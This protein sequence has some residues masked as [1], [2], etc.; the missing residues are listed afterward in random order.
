MVT[1]IDIYDAYQHSFSDSQRGNSDGF[2]CNICGKSFT[3]KGNLTDHV[4]LHQGIYRY[5]CDICGKGFRSKM[6]YEGH[7]NTHTD[8]RPYK[9]SV[10]DKAFSYIQS[11]RKHVVI[12]KAPSYGWMLVVLLTRF[13]SFHT[14]FSRSHSYCQKNFE[15]Q[16]AKKLDFRRFLETNMWDL[17][18]CV[19]HHCK[20]T[21][22]RESP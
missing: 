14:W 13:I 16:Q 20:P 8:Y 15:H 22:T 2:I 1:G 6:H 5:K 11:F 7:M 18:Q 10:C 17:W 4:K 12:C 21:G 19:H 3:M 9:C